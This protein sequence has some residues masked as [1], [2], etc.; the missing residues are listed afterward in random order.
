MTLT[1]EGHC[2]ADS[3]QSVTRVPVYNAALKRNELSDA[4]QSINSGQKGGQGQGEQNIL[5]EQGIYANGCYTL[6]LNQVFMVTALH[7]P[8]QK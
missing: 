1:S 6:T 3:A 4:A 2:T 8:L 7:H 5:H